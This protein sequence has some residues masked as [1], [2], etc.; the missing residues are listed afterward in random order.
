MPEAATS[1]AHAAV[2]TLSDGLSS[3]LLQ[4]APIPRSRRRDSVWCGG[5]LAGWWCPRWLLAAACGSRTVAGSRSSCRGGSCAW[6][7]QPVIKG[8]AGGRTGFM[9]RRR[10]SKGTYGAVRARGSYK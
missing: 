10:Q 9:S 8:T 3:L 2:T 5:W 7:H 1:K 6:I 4:L